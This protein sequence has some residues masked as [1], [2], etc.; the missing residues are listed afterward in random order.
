MKRNG[1][2]PIGHH[3]PSIHGHH[4]YTEDNSVFT[5]IVVLGFCLLCQDVLS[6]VGNKTSCT[7][8]AYLVL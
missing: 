5:A 8:L 7:M 2:F 1:F 4:C 6:I 3:C